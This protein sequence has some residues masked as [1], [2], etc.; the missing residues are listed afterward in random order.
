MSNV[1]GTINPV[2]E[3]AAHLHSKDIKILV[4]GAQSVPN[5]NVDVQDI[6]CDFLSFSAHKMVGPTGM[7]ILY[8]RKELLQEMD[9]FMGGGEMIET[10]T[11]ENATWAGIPH[12]F[13][14][15]TPNIAG[16]FGLAAAID[17]LKNI[18]M[19]NIYAYKNR[20]TR[21][22]IDNMRRIDGLKIYGNAPA[23]GSAISF[24]LKNVHPFDL[25]QFLDQFGIATRAGHHCAQPLMKKL[26]VSATSRASLY[27][28]NTFQEVDI[29]VDKLE[30]AIKF[31]A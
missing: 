13:E 1:L 20:L 30:Q 28:Y 7:G 9:P 2:K 29:F 19:D 22:A 5:M 14:A 24:R 23:R 27:F 18:G 15:G 12:K 26:N 8:A 3:I 25:S 21:Y 6:D 16:A 11:K 17:Y 31:F 4:D 10:V